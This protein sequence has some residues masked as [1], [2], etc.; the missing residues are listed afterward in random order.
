MTRDHNRTNVSFV[1]LLKG[2]GGTKW[3]TCVDEEK[4]S[5]FT[6]NKSSHETLG[7]TTF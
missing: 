5:G 3:G 4:S 7:E 1:G 2:K 6:F